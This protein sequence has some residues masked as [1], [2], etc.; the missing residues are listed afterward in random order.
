MLVQVGQWIEHH[1]HDIADVVI[2]LSLGFYILREFIGPRW[3]RLKLKY[4][5][6][7]RFNIAS[8]DQIKGLKYVIQ[9]DKEHNS[10]LLVLPAHTHNLL[11]HVLW[12]HRL[13]FIQSELEFW[14]EDN[15]DEDDRKTVPLIHYW[16]HPFVKVGDTKRKPG[17]YPGHYIDY[18]DNYHIEAIRNRAKGSVVTNAF[19]IS[20]RDP[21]LYRFKMRVVADGVEATTWLRVRIEE[22][23]T[24]VVRCTRHWRCFVT[25]RP[26]IKY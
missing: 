23:P 21:G 14:F 4:P 9:D 12:T 11:L 20:T 1:L 7:A 16:F 15:K 19:M 18:H 24:T 3:R 10:K 2:I 26:V 22:S 25:P 17:E 5:L 13:D 8:R 6:K